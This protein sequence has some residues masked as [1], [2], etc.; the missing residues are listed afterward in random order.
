M[1]D[2]IYVYAEGTDFARP[3]EDA[4]V[5][6]LGDMA[7]RRK[8]MFFSCSV[9]NQR[10][11]D[12]WELGV[13]L[14]FEAVEA[15]ALPKQWFTDIETVLDC[16]ETLARD[17]DLSFVFGLG[18]DG[19]P[20]EDIFEATI[21]RAEMKRVIRDIITQ[22]ALPPG[23][24]RR[25]VRFDIED[26]R[27]VASFGDYR[28]AFGP[29]NALVFGLADGERTV[30]DVIRD[31]TKQ[32]PPGIGSDPTIDV[33]DAIRSL[34]RQGFVALTERKAPL[35]Y[36]LAVPTSEQDVQRAH[37]EMARDGFDPTLDPRRRA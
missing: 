13:N 33:V 28:A 17:F 27:P 1:A 7:E 32:M 22:P 30:R 20:G 15:G 5:T 9:V 2:V 14:S 12:D 34:S 35:P 18:L 3:V 25:T 4:V 16:V 23:W 21:D 29:I 8:W 10:R 31:V 6:R 26:G 36:Y 11:G 24:L 37:A 19:K